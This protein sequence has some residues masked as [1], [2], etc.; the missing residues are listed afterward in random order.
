MS[1]LN[2]KKVCNFFVYTVYEI[3]AIFSNMEPNAQPKRAHTQDLNLTEIIYRF[4]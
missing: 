1:L 4:S 3:P 2:G